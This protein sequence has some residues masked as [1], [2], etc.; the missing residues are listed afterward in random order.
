MDL[1][2]VQD[3]LLADNVLDGRFRCDVIV[4]GERRE[5]RVGARTL[6]QEVVGSCFGARWVLRDGWLYALDGKPMCCN[7][8]AS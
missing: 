1:V 6:W 3:Q 2:E 4:A 8:L 5:G 7:E